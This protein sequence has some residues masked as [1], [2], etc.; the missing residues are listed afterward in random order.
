MLL[1]QYSYVILSGLAIAALLVWAV[2]RG[3]RTERLVAVAALGLGCA[4]A[5]WMFA[6]EATD[7]SASGPPAAPIG[8]GTPVLLE[9]QSPY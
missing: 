9:F 8:A 4:L 6:P 7:P 3:P 1:N 5:F 2:A